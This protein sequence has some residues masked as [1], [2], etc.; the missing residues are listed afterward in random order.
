MIDQKPLQNLKEKPKRRWYNRRF[1]VESDSSKR[2]KEK[3]SKLN[4]KILWRFFKVFYVILVSILYILSH[5]DINSY[6]NEEIIPF[7]I[8]TA[9]LAFLTSFLIFLIIRRIV[10]YIAFGK[11]SKI[12]ISNPEKLVI[13]LIIILAGCFY[14]F[15]YRP[16]Q[17][18]RECIK[19][20]D[21]KVKSYSLLPFNNSYEKQSQRSYEYYRNC[22]RER[23]MK[24]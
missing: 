7:L 12:T 15:E 19:G 8:T 18:R 24:E 1:L 3:I 21:A 11:T 9:I 20:A 6:L 13:F 17:I 14:W 4:E 22:L 5:S 16:S 10:V 23:G 2:R